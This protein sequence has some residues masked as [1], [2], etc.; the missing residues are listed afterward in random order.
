MQ[1]TVQDWSIGD[2][3][4]WLD[5]NGLSDYQTLFCEEHKI[6]GSVLLSLTEEDLRKPPV[7]LTVLG[8]CHIFMLNIVLVPV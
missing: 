5:E 6:D 4:V 3:A 2:V 7:Q 8:M 1:R